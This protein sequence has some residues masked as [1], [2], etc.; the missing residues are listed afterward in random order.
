MQT[1]M[2]VLADTGV[3]ASMRQGDACGGAL[4]DHRRLILTGL[5]MY[6]G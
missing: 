1:F 6:G 4:G 2:F 3:P 5:V